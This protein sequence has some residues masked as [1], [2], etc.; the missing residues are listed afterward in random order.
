MKKAT[1]FTLFLALATLAKP[2]IAVITFEGDQTTTPEQR[3]AISDRIQGELLA[4]DSF[5]VLD[6]GNINTILKEQNF[7]ASG[8]CSDNSCQVQM[9]QLLGVEKMVTGKVVNFGKVWSLSSTL[10]DVTSG[11]VVRSAAVDVRGELYD[12]LGKGCPQLAQKLV[13]VKSEQAKSSRSMTWIKPTL[14]WGGLG[15]AVLGSALGYLGDAKVADQNQKVLD[16]NDEATAT[17]AGKEASS[18]ATL[19]NVGLGIAGLGAVSFG[20]SFAF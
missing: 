16:A 1:L 20:M 11:M 15:V 12:V 8:I 9:G 19:R 5:T 17:A 13:G 18:A 6:R 7:Q 2:Q 10:L 14:L 4:T 3:A